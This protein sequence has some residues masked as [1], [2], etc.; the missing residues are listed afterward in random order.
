MD[1]P[2]YSSG[3]RYVWH[4]L[5]LDPDPDVVFRAFKKTQV[6][7][8]IRKA[9]REGLSV[10]RCSSLDAVRVFYGLHVRTRKRQGMPVQPW[11]F[12]S[13]LWSR[14]LDQGHG[15]VSLAY[16]DGRPIAGAVFLSQGRRLTYKYSASDLAFRKSR[17]NNLVLW[18]AIEWACLNG[19]ESMDWGRTD[20]GD[21]GLRTFK[22][23]WGT[24]EEPLAYCY[25]GYRPDNGSRDGVGF[26]G[27]SWIIKHGPPAFC[28]LTGELFYGHFA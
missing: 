10:R 13:R 14:V 25:Y 20:S 23:G 1:S 2:E 17:P 5:A 24:R 15:F 27:A 21:D 8:R 6:Q 11:R 22:T 28:R 19:F 3:D 7:Q 12:F 26:R 16:V 18:D 9:I 4:E